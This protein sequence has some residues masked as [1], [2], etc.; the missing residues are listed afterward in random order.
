MGHREAQYKMILGRRNT[1]QPRTVADGNIH[2][3]LEPRD[4]IGPHRPR[5]PH[6]LVVGRLAVQPLV[7]RPELS[8]GNPNSGSGQ[9]FGVRN[10]RIR[11]VV[12][13]TPASPGA[14]ASITDARPIPAR[15]NANPIPSPACPPP[16][17][18]TSWSNGVARTQLA[19]AGPKYRS[20]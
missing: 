10:V 1:D 5:D 4:V 13:H 19:G 11:A 8:S 12:V 15:R 18:T 6:Q 2:R 20:R 3:P 9:T 17:T 7:P 14:A 16:T